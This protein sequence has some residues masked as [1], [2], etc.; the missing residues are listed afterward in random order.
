MFEL[1]GVRPEVADEAL[2]RAAQK[3]PLRCKI[4]YRDTAGE[5]VQNE[6]E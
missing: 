6:A 5:V 4:V 2:R 3:L 1:G